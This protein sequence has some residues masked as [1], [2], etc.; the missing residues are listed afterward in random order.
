MANHEAARQFS[1][2][3]PPTLV[4]RVEHCAEEIRASGLE[5]TRADVV[6][7]LLNHALD[8]THCKL[9][10]LLGGKSRKTRRRKKA[11]S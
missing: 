5:L 8:T 7:L 2:R 10:L 9:E 3:L 4:D 1:F 6:R 11:G